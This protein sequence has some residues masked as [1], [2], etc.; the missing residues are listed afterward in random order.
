MPHQRFGLLIAVLENVPLWAGLGFA[1]WIASRRLRAS[2]LTASLLVLAVGLIVADF[3]IEH[4]RALIHPDP[5]SDWF[6]LQTVRRI[7]ST[8][9]LWGLAAACALAA[10]WRSGH[11][12]SSEP[13]G[14]EESIR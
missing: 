3:L 5:R 7:A 9:R 11:R 2:R 14:P 10:V 4:A 12:V 13:P 1:L 6:I 8:P